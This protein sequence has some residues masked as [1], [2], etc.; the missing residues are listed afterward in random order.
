MNKSRRSGPSIGMTRAVR[1]TV[2]WPSLTTRLSE[3]LAQG[4][5]TALGGDGTSS[6]LAALFGAVGSIK[7]AA[8]PGEKA[9]SLTALGLAWSLDQIRSDTN[10]EDSALRDAMHRAIN[11]AKKSIDEGEQ[12]VPVTFLDRPTTLPIYHVLR[13]AIVAEKDVFRRGVYESDAS[14]AA[15]LDSA[16]DRALFEILSHRYDVYRSLSEALNAPGKESSERQINWTAYRSRIIDEFEIK[17]VFGQETTKVSLS[18]LYIPLRA[19]W[20]KPEDNSQENEAFDISETHEIC[21]LE[22][23]LISWIES[24]NN[25]DDNIRLIGGGPGSGKSTSLK[26]IARIVA[27]RPEWRPLFIPL[28]RLSLEG[29]LRDAI[30]RFFTDKSGGAF[31]QGPLTRTAVEDGPPLLLIFD[32]LDEISRPGEAANE[33]VNLFATKMSNLVAA[34]RGDGAKTVKVIASGR[35]PAFQAAKRFLSP[36]PGGCLEVYGYG[37]LR[38]SI[39]TPQELWK[40]DQRQHWWKKYA[41]L[42]NLTTELPA[43]FASSRLASITHEPLLCYLLVLS[44][45]ATANWEEA[46]E[47]PNR[48][49]KAL[50]ESVWYRGWGDGNQRRQGPGKTLTLPDFNAL[51]QT[52]A[53]AA[54]QGGD[55][56]VASETSFSAAINITRNQRSW[57]NFKTDNG[58]DVTNL[59]MNFYLK[60]SEGDQRGFEFTHKSFGDYLAARA[61]LD[62]AFDLPALISRNVDY[63]M[64][65]WLIATGSGLLTQEIL[66]FMRDEVR[67]RINDSAPE[68]S[69]EDVCRLKLAFERLISTILMDGL[70]ANKLS[71]AWRLVESKQRNAE[72]MAWSV[73]NSLVLGLET[74]SNNNLAI[75]VDWPDKLTSFHS[76]LRRI[77][78]VSSLNN[79]A[80]KCFSYISAPTSNLFGLSLMGIDLRGANL[81]G[82]TLAGCHLISANLRNANLRNADF[83]RAMLDRAE[84][85]GADLSGA[86]LADARLEGTEWD[87]ATLDG[88]K[89]SELS[90]L[91]ADLEY[92]ERVRRNL[93][94]RYI[95]GDMREANPISQKRVGAIRKLVRS[96]GG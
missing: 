44:G 6:A 82:A 68:I 72:I 33:I 24:N 12:I 59:A 16:F 38:H 52:I 27:D 31:T 76:L 62:V 42:L 57:Q 4:F 13:D 11:S 69:P 10:I 50:I 86:D 54:W 60:S 85:H 49:Y 90:L 66:T 55:T 22:E 28:Q 51:M 56:R 75:K 88:A 37:P 39:R 30:N 34:L 93:D 26:S 18:Q 9:W 20:K 78:D 23:S 89:I 61:I 77:G 29:D 63:A 40:L 32:G 73:V 80:L 70:P 81:E 47:N 19:I 83:Q 67:L 36:P 87:G 5:L 7:V 94:R 17:P 2:D 45:Y 43:A 79:V 35:M 53:L 25:N 95:G 46:A 74:K 91:F 41:Q 21:M 8:P 71:G 48:I 3:V 65:D 96:M 64:N 15:R 1:L 92:F 58:E 84:L 14:L